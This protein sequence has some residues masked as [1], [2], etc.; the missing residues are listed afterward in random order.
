MRK[1]V[2]NPGRKPKKVATKKTVRKNPAKKPATK[3]TYKRNP[4]AD[5][6]LMALY[7]EKME[8]KMAKSRKRSEAAK[9]AARTR[10]KNQLALGS[11]KSTPKRRRRRT[12]KLKTPRG[13]SVSFRPISKKGARRTKKQ[14]WVKNPINIGGTI[15]TLGLGMAGALALNF[16]TNALGKATGM[17]D[18]NKTYVK[19][20][21]AVIVPGLAVKK[22]SGVA[23]ESALAGSLV[24]GGFALRDLL[25][26]QF[27]A[28]PTIQ[29]LL[30]GEHDLTTDDIMLLDAYAN[31]LNGAS[32]EL[33]GAQSIDYDP[34]APAY[35][36]EMAGASVELMGAQSIDFNSFDEGW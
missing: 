10:R 32:V 4:G 14:L 17:S 3:R 33:M 18:Q 27:A 11:A 31:E 20:A 2:V 30:S 26:T 9:K 25:K 8:T 24:F 29:E 36:A 21:L 15:K 28:N 35:D 16:L 19:L 34:M 12:I 5:D 22:L 13:K 1:Y 23:R 6:D 7:V